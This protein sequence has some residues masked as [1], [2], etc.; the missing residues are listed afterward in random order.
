M[1]II[2]IEK[3]VLKETRFVAL[4]ILIFS[5]FMEAVFLIINAWDYR[6][7]LGNLLSGIIGV[8]NF[9]LLGITVQKAVNSG[10]E[11]EARRLMKSSQSIRLVMIFAVAVIG[12][13]V[14]VFNLWATLIPLLFP[15]LSMIIRGIQLKRSGGNKD[16]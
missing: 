7:L 4:W 10:D 1:I 16:E 5:V 2:K 14:P 12:A 6:V 11:G 13:T 15:R 9:L 8:V 3:T